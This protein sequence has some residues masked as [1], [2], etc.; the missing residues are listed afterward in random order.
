MGWRDALTGAMGTGKARRIGRQETER[1][2]DGAATDADRA[3]LAELLDLAA[4]PALPTERAGRTEAVAAFTRAWRVPN[5]AGVPV[6]RA[7]VLSMLTRA[8]LV[9]LA[10][11]LAVVL[12][13]GTAQAAGTGTLPA[14]VQHRAH[15]LLNPV[16]IPVPDASTHSSGAGPGPSGTPGS[17][18]PGLIAPTDTGAPDALGLCQAWFEQRDRTQGVD[19]GVLKRL[20][21]L[22]GGSDHIPAYCAGILAT[23]PTPA[24]QTPTADA[25]PSHPGKAKGHDHPTPTPSPKH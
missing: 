17:A 7:R 23:A 5:P 12:V 14:G 3:G 15:D 1:L 2:L 21:P 13:G 9:K 22:A 18:R 24:A 6:R 20:G 19:P 8:A 11:V 4:G 10:A 16:G 25:T